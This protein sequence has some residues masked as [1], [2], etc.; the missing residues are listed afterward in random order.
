MP[1]E[2]RSPNGS[3]ED[4]AGPSNETAPEREGAPSEGANSE[5]AGRRPLSADSDIIIKGG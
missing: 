3:N 2:N 1:D 5:H 4:L